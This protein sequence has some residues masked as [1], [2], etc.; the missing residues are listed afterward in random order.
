MPDQY[1]DRHQ[2]PNSRKGRPNV[3]G[4][5]GSRAENTLWNHF[6]SSAQPPSATPP[7]TRPT[8][9]TASNLSGSPLHPA[10]RQATPVDWQTAEIS[11]LRL[12]HA[13]LRASE[14]EWQ[15][16]AEIWQN[17]V[18]VRDDTIE[19]LRSDVTYLQTQIQGLTGVWPSVS[20]ARSR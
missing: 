6:R 16:K 4:T 19:K 7:T 8:A 14:A 11:R 13:N 18:C 9:S 12:E 10:I 17:E 20:S 5:I 1:S 3:S 15:R 2:P